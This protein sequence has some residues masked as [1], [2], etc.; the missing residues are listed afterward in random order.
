MAVVALADHG[1]GESVENPRALRASSPVVVARILLQHSRQDGAA[2]KGS[3]KNVAVGSAETLGIALRALTVSAPAVSRLIEPGH[4]TDR[5]ER[6]RVG[7]R[8]PGKRELMSWRERCSVGY[9]ADV[10]IRYEAEYALLL[11]ILYLR[12]G[13]L[14]GGKGDAHFGHLGGKN[15]SD[16]RGDIGLSGMDVPG[17]RLRGQAFRADREMERPW[18]DI[19]EKELPVFIR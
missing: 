11:L 7:R 17:E 18:S 14:L 4:D 6:H 16:Q 13:D 3:S 8:L 1:V 15:Q 2:N 19:G 5:G 10:K 9:I 12:V